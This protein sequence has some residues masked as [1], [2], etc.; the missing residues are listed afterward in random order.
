MRFCSHAHHILP[1]QHI[2]RNRATRKNR[3]IC[4]VHNLAFF[5]H[6]GVSRRVT[7]HLLK[8]VSLNRVAVDL[9]D[10]RINVQVC[11]PSVTSTY[12]AMSEYTREF[13][14]TC[15]SVT[16]RCT[17]QFTPKMKANAEPRL[18]SSLV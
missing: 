8:V 18:L 13:H 14:E 15:H 6:D 1:S 7:W 16:S 4:R 17:G 5:G 2:Y 9:H 12:R 11:H 10:P 3:K